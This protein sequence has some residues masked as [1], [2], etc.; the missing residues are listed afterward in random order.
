[1][2]YDIELLRADILKENAWWP[3]NFQIQ[4]RNQEPR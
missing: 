4:S 1:M 3:E 2:K